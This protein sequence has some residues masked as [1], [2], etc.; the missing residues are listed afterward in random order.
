MAADI[1]TSVVVEVVVGIVVVVVHAVRCLLDDVERR[2]V[3]CGRSVNPSKRLEL[4]F[5][6]RTGNTPAFL[7]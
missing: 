6:K 2:G 5:K 4:G 3:V 7:G 1:V